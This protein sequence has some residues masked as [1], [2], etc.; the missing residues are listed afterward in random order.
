M[1]ILSIL[2]ALILAPTI[3]VLL[4]IGLKSLKF[5]MNSEFVGLM[6]FVGFALWY[7]FKYELM[8]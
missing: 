1:S 7:F 8:G 5:A 6:I 3:T 4:Y 2:L